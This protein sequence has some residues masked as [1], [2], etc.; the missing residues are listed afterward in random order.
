MQTFADEFPPICSISL[1]PKVL[2]E[3]T[4]LCYLTSSLYREGRSGAVGGSDC[5]KIGDV[6]L[7]AFDLAAVD[8]Y[9]RYLEE[10][11]R[12]MHLLE[13]ALSDSE[14]AAF[15]QL[16]KD[17]ESQKVC[18]LPL[19]S[20]ILKPLH[21]LLHYELLVERLLRSY[22]S[23]HPDYQSANM[24]MIKLQTIIRKM[25]NRIHE[26][27][28][29]IKMAEIQ[30]DLGSS[31]EAGL[32]SVPGR[33]FIREGCLRKLSRKGYQQRMFFL[34]SD[35][36][37]YSNRTTNPTLHFRVH[38][39]L[40]VRELSVL[41]SEARMEA[42]HCFNIYDGKKALL[43]AA[44][45]Q[46]EKI[47]WMEDIAEAAQTARAASDPAMTNGSQNKFMSLKSMSG[48]ED[49]LDRSNN[50]QTLPSTSSNQRTNSSV[51]VCW[52]RATTLAKKEFHMSLQTMLSGYLLR[53]F[54]NS[55]GWQKLWVVFTNSCLYFFKTFQDDFP[56]ASL[57]LLGYEVQKPNAEDAI[58]KDFVFKLRF[59]NHVYF[60][61]AESQY[62]FDRW[63]EVLGTA[64][65]VSEEFDSTPNDFGQNGA[66]EALQ[67]E[68]TAY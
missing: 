43:V 4:P 62:T 21:R 46:E 9:G 22:N 18:Y 38:G 52:H 55:N 59:K 40:P 44:A 31:Y 36:L 48:S 49:C 10:H 27:E 45:N 2:N 41:D 1:L 15:Q 14:H 65:S 39:A 53:K 29:F 23:S 42:D 12:I 17:F 54:K 32:L 37:L 57:P 5:K 56:L 8:H 6:L 50:D 51:H 28:N 20:L 19:T 33:E 61:R 30:R 67:E 66:G 16:F 13:Q 25:A 63:I 35:L 26:S 3:K 11:L 60:F 68:Y 24:A 34:F 47:Q 64:T 7:H 58:Q